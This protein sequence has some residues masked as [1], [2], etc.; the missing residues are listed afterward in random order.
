MNFR[1]PK[2]TYGKPVNPKTTNNKHITENQQI[3]RKKINNSTPNQLSDEEE[4]Q[5]MKKKK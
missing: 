1:S 3:Q 5:I 4:I 2:T